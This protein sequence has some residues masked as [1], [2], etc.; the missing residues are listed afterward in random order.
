MVWV[1][2]LRFFVEQVLMIFVFCKFC[3]IQVVS[4]VFFVNLIW[5]KFLNKEGVVVNF[6]LVKLLGVLFFFCVVL[7]VFFQ[8]QN[9]WW[10]GWQQRCL[11]FRLN[12]VVQK[13]VVEGVDGS[14]LEFLFEILEWRLDVN[15]FVVISVFVFW[16]RNLKLLELMLKLLFGRFVLL[17]VLLILACLLI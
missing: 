12:F 8:F 4:R 5:L 9:F 13:L 10:F 6:E 14:V 2:N 3:I 11:V 1:R 15:E 16:F 7:S 17:Q